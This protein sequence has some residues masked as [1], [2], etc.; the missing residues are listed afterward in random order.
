MNLLILVTVYLQHGQAQYPSKI[1]KLNRNLQASKQIDRPAIQSSPSLRSAYIAT[2]VTRRNAQYYWIQ[3]KTGFTLIYL[4]FKG[5][6]VLE[7]LFRVC[8]HT[9]FGVHVFHPGRLE[10]IG[11]WKKH[12]EQAFAAEPAGRAVAVGN[13]GGV[14]GGIHFKKESRDKSGTGCY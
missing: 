1:N 6:S 13:Q 3:T 10:L 2:K 11:A 8:H 14:V 5:D 9:R 12:A 4:G 7:G